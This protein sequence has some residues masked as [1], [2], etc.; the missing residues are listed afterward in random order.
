[1]LW[2]NI[3]VCLEEDGVLYISIF[4]KASVIGINFRMKSFYLSYLLI[5]LFNPYC[6]LEGLPFLTLSSALLCLP[7]PPTHLPWP[8]CSLSTYYIHPLQV[9][10]AYRSLCME[11]SSLRYLAH[12]LIPFRSLLNYHFMRKMPLLA[13]LCSY[14]LHSCHSSAPLPTWLFTWHMCVHMYIILIKLTF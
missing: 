14:L 11:S 5:H 10:H 13:T 3:C 7:R 2:S 1:M 8:L 12:M 6:G 4:K 9:F